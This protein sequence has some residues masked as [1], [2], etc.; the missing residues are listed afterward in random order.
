MVQVPPFN[1][2]VTLRTSRWS[3]WSKTSGMILPHCIVQLS[4]QEKNVHFS[5]LSSCS[6]DNMLEILYIFFCFFFYF[7]LNKSYIKYINTEGNSLAYT[8]CVLILSFLFCLCAHS[9]TFGK[10]LIKLSE[11]Y[12]QFFLVLSY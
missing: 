9:C 4:S 1:N 11:L 5:F 8:T 10:L 3:S 2:I 12:Y 7:F 6:W